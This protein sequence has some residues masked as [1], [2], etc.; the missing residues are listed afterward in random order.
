[1]RDTDWLW[2]GLT[3]FI[4]LAVAFM[5]PV[6]PNDYWWYLRLGQDIL[7]DGRVPTSEAYSLTQAGQP[8]VYQSWLSAVLMWALYHMGGIPLTVL[9]RGLALDDAGLAALGQKLKAACGSGGTVKDGVI[10]VQGDHRER[11][12]QLLQTQGVA[13]RIAG[14]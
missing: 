6:L 4:V 3:L 14:G 1:M 10:E 12:L 9:V 7:S 2:M 5:L 13:A 8:V 11:I